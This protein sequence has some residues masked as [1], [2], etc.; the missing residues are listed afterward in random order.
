MAASCPVRA[1]MSGSRGMIAPLIS[2]LE[3]WLFEPPESLIGKPVW[4][5]ARV[6]QY[7]YALIRDFLK[8]DL[9][10][11]ATGLVYTT[12]LSIVPLI[13]L[14]F[15][16]LKGLGFHRELKPLL[17]SFLE[18]IGERAGEVTDQI[19]QFVDNVRGGLLGSVGLVFVICTV[20]SVVQK[21]EESFNFIWRVEQPRSFGRR[22]SEYL[23]VMV[24]GPAVVVAA[25]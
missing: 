23:S 3:H 20:I 9:T 18:P 10:L 25:I 4:L 5:V 8:G 24:V 21:V 7:P 12:L 1:R 2:R 16:V 19:M 11:R 6:L 15:S 22:F 14:S 13:A 17:L